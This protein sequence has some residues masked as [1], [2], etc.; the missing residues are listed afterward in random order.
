MLIF[1]LIRNEV[2]ASFDIIYK[3]KTQKQK[4]NWIERLIFISA[5]NWLGQL[6]QA[7]SF[8]ADPIFLQWSRQ[9]LQQGLILKT[10]KQKT[11]KTTQVLINCNN[12]IFFLGN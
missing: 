8:S 6:V 9:N 12:R 1:L 5:Y 11:K 2:Q 10:N 4:K 3:I 7:W